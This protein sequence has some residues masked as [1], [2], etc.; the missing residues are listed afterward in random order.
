MKKTLISL[1]IA[2]SASQAYGDFIGIYAGV[3][4]W[5]ADPSGFIGSNA[6]S[7]SAQELKLD[8]E[9]NAFFYVAFEHPIPVLPNVKLMHSQLSVSGLGDVSR[10]FIFNDTTFTADAEIQSEIDLSHTDAT[11][12]YEILDNWI[13][14]DIGITGRLFSSFAEL[15]NDD[16]NIRTKAELNGAVPLGYVKAQFDLPF[17]GWYVGGNMNYINFRG[18]S[19]RDVEARIGY[20]F[21]GVGLDFGVELGYRDMQLTV[22]EVDDFET[23]LGVDGAT[24]TG[25]LHF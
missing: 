18:D 4:G 13:S 7:V 8:G 17:S 19:F 3:G 11:L 10:E 21:G 25:I 22:D 2:A 15:S 6:D 12:Y 9:T 5:S 16:N 14:L 23:D 24:L 20:M 1:V